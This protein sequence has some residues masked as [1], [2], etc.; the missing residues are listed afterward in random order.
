[1]AHSRILTSF[2]WEC[3]CGATPAMPAEFA[4]RFLADLTM[5]HELVTFRDVVISFSQEEWEYLDSAQR[6]L[7]WDVMMENY[8][9]LVSLDLESK[10]EIKTL[11]VGKGIIE[12]IGSQCEKVKESTDFIGLESTICR[13]DRQSTNKIE[14]QVSAMACFHQKK[15][16]TEKVPNCKN[17]VSLTMHQRNHDSKKPCEY[18]GCS[19]VLNCDLK[20]DDYEKIYSGEKFNECD[21]CWKTFGV[22]DPHNLQ[23]NIHTDVKPCLYM[24]YGNAFS[25]YEDLRAHHKIH[26]DRKCYKYKE[27][28]RTFRRNEETTPLERIHS[29]EKP[30]ECTFCGKSFRVHA[31]LNRHQKIHTDEK[32]YKCMECGKDFRFHSQLTE[33]HRIHTG[34][35]PYKCEQCE[36]FFRISSQLIE[37]QRIHTGEKPYEC[38]ECGKAF[39]V[40]RELARHQRI[41]TGKSLN[42][43][44]YW[45]H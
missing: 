2:T 42:V 22:D 36:K 3:V 29:G 1:M 15:T 17:Q 32:P 45:Q 13:N 16:T 34:E 37:H 8:S 4:D 25:F 24:K 27:Y 35:K 31:Q 5:G 33:H 38:K 39:G 41:H 6:D 12:N 18:K 19:K 28:K 11:S 30:Y 26:D 43:T 23:L 20:F 40:C 21:R 9:N 7:Y 10:Y 14:V 44:S